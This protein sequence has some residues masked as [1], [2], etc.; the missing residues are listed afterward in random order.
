MLH[1]RDSGSQEQ[2]VSKRLHQQAEFSYSSELNSAK[3]MMVFGAD[4]IC[5]YPKQISNN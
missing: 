1:R 5:K 4:L 2:N 3:E